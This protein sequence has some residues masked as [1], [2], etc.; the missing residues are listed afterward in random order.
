MRSNIFKERKSKSIK[1]CDIIQ[2][3]EILKEK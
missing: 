3:K 2:Y 1:K